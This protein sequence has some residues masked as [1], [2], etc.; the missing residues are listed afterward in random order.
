MADLNGFD[1][2]SVEPNAGFDPIPAGKYFVAVT[3]TD[4][5]ATKNGKGEFLEI[6]MQVLEGPHKGRKL[7]DRLT[8][9]HPN[10]QTV[11]IAR[12]TLSA[13]CRAAGVMK[14]KDSVE[15]H[16]IPV[17]ASV[18]VKNRDDT[19]EPSNVIKGYAKRGASGGGASPVAVNGRP[20]PGGPVA[21]AATNGSTPPWKR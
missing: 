17:V 7:W 5:K 18:A 10:E 2:H 12:A 9:R 8:L 6:E 20:S 4:M 14:P 3:G 1:A 15:L 19:G 21:A 11:E 13:L 16:N